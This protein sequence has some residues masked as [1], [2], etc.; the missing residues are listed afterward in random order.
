MIIIAIILKILVFDPLDFAKKTSF[1]LFL[2]KK[3]DKYENLFKNTTESENYKIIKLPFSK[4]RRVLFDRVTKNFILTGDSEYLT[5]SR[6]INKN[7]EEIDSLKIRGYLF[8]SGVYFYEDYCID[9]AITGNKSK[10]K[11]DTIINYDS[12]SKEEFEDYLS[13]ATIVDFTKKHTDYKGF[14]SLEN[15]KGRCH[16]KIQDKWIVI[17]SKKMFDELEEDYEKDYFELKHKNFSKKNEPRLITL[18]NRTAPIKDWKKEDNIIFLQKF[19]KKSRQR[20]GLMNHNGLGR[21][22][23]NGTGY[24]Q[25]T[26]NSEVFNFKSYT[27]ESKLFT[28]SPFVPYIYSFKPDISVYFPEKIYNVDIAF[29]LSGD[30]SGLS[31]QPTESRGVYV[32]KKK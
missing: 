17:E 19:K 20:T 16:L 15:H 7:G 6:K 14:K 31:N 24:F 5:T 2:N 8:S 28:Y 9:W 10:Q 13:K 1:D 4:P 23:W 12:L 27:F 32:L 11:Y 18:S 25:L 21:S 3:Y 30:A 29:I 26:H 22:G